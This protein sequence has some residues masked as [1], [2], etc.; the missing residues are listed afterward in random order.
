MKKHTTAERLMEPYRW[1]YWMPP[2]WKG[3]ET[4]QGDVIFQRCS[5]SSNQRSSCQQEV[6]VNASFAVSSGNQSKTSKSRLQCK[7]LSHLGLRPSRH[8]D[9]QSGKQRYSLENTNRRITAQ[10]SRISEQVYALL[11]SLSLRKSLVCYLA[12]K[13]TESVAM[14]QK[15]TVRP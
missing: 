15:M 2:G 8:N 12:F 1:Q 4:N 11:Q 6:W 10:T 9:T 14:R 3:S 13:E 7:L 5:D